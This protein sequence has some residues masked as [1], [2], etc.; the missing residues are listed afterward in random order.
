ME[1]SWRNRANLNQNEQWKLAKDGLEIVKQI[2]EIGDKA[3]SELE[4]SDV[5][6]LKWAG[7]YAQRPRDGH[8]LIRVKLPSGRLNSSQARVL[9]GIAK[10]YGRD[11]LQITVRQ[12]MQIHWITLADAPDILGRLERIGLSSIE[13]CGDV[14]RTI[15]GNPLAGID[16]EEILDTTPIVQ[17]VF[18]YFLGHPEF[19]SLPRKLKISIS[20]N[21]HDAGFARINDIA[22]VPAKRDDEAG[23]HVY[24]GGGLSAEPYLAEKLPFF[25]RPKDV[26]RI[27]KAIATIFREYGYRENRGHCRLKYLIADF[28]K[29]RFAKLVEQLAGPLEHGGVEI[30]QEWNRGAFYGIHEQ[31][32]QGMFYF[33]TNVPAGFLQADEL[34]EFACLADNYG[35]G[36]L[37]TTNSQNMV[38]INIPAQN[39][40]ALKDEILFEKFGLAPGCFSGYAASCTGNAFC[41]FSPI[42]TKHRLQA[43]TEEL[44]C[45]FPE[46]DVPFQI[47]LTGC[48]HS[49]AQPQIADIGLT[50][51]RAKLGDTIVDTFGV[52]LGG[53]LGPQAKYAIVLD[54]KV[55]ESQLAAFIKQLV[56][57]YL[58]HRKEQERFYELVRRTDECAFQQLLD[59]FKFDSRL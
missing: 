21:P 58:E 35:N 5:E 39:V 29:D 23:F 4:P 50:G 11:G 7:I 8:F 34:L 17:D 36:Q 42:E 54:G 18:S 10:D 14:P 37:R 41:N 2:P 12:A 53:T 13:A 19:S 43:L 48:I 47:N 32:Q 22:F 56:R 27:T 52:Q 6:R 33:G 59:R 57:Y 38:L 9:A 28:G 3:F 16:P 40:D 25:S 51:G 44:D 31:K 45:T 30:Q 1:K 20:A 15:L 26:L 46:V 55:A 24:A 49:C